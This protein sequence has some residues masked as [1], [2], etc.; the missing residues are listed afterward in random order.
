MVINFIHTFDFSTISKN[1]ISITF[2]PPGNI[3]IRDFIIY[4]SNEVLDQVIKNNIEVVCITFR[5]IGVLNYFSN[6]YY[7]HQRVAN[8]RNAVKCNLINE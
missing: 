8:Q 6:I 7:Q 4:F 1:S 3:L 2:F 5:F